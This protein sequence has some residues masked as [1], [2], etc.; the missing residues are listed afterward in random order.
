M[1]TNENS[2]DFG[3]TQLG[4]KL[5]MQYNLIEYRCN[6]KLNFVVALSY[7]LLLISVQTLCGFH[8]GLRTQLILFIRIGWHL[9]VSMSLLIYMNGLILFLGRFCLSFTWEDHLHNLVLP[10]YCVTL[11][12][13]FEV[14]GVVLD[15]SKV[16]FPLNVVSSFS[17]SFLFKRYSLHTQV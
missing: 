13:I 2:I 16:T 3:T 10:M 12:E 5:G 1:L 7:H 11:L 6:T 9:R 17:F 14:W 4:E 15:A 8:L